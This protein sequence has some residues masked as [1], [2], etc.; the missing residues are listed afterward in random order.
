MR[1]IHLDPDALKVESFVTAPA[2][3]G[4]GTVRGHACSVPVPQEPDP[5]DGGN[6]DG[7]SGDTCAQSCWNT[8]A[9]SCNGTCHLS[10][11]ATC[12]DYT[13]NVAQNTCYEPNP[14]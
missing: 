6:G 10:C 14:R 8:C 12:Y 11:N 4:G 13:C 7:G 9:A 3:G 2:R 5:R 1:K